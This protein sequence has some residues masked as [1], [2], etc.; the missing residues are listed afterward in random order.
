MEMADNNWEQ[1]HSQAFEQSQ[2]FDTFSKRTEDIRDKAVRR[3][4]ATED[5]ILEAKKL[6][7]SMSLE[8]VR[9]LMEKMQAVHNDDPNF[10]CVT[11]QSIKKF[12]A[13]DDVMEN[14]ERHKQ[15]IQE[16]K[17]EA[18]LI[19]NNSPYAEVRAV[20]D[21]HDDAG[22]PVSTTRA[23]TIGIVFSCLAAFANQSLRSKRLSRFDTD[24]I[25]LLAY[26]VGKA[27]ERW[28][29]RVNMRI[30]FTKHAISSN[31]GRFNKK[32][33]MLIVL[34]ANAS[35]GLPFAQYTIWTQVLPPYLNWEYTKSFPY[36][37]LNSF[38]SNLLGYGVAGLS[39]RFLVYPSRCV[40]PKSL[41]TIALNNALHNDKN[42][43]VKGPFG[44]M[45][46]MSRRAFFLVSF[47]AMF[48]YF[49]FPKFIFQKLKYFSWM[50]WIAPDNVMLNAVAG[51]K[52]GLG[53]LN[54]LPTFDWSVITTGNSDPLTIPAFSTFSFAGGMFIT[55]LMILGIWCTNTWNTAYLPVNSS[56]IFNHFGEV[57]DM[58]FVL[59]DNGKLD[60]EK[61]SSY[62]A[63]YLSA[64]NLVFYG[65]YFAL[66]SAVV[67]HVLLYYRHELMTGLGI[68]AQR[69]RWRRSGAEAQG[70]RE[71]GTARVINAEDLDV[72]RRLMAAYPQ[73]SEWFYFALVVISI[74]CGVL[75]KVLWPSPASPAVVLY[76][77][78]LC[79]LF[80]IPI[81][82]FAATTGLE[83]T[84]HVLSALIGSA[85]VDGSAFG[86]NFFATYSSATCTQALSI[87]KDFKIAHYVKIPPRVTFFGHLL[88]TFISTVICAAVVRS[89][90]LCRET[91][92]IRTNSQVFLT[93]SAFW[94]SI[95]PGKVFGFHGQY[96]WLLLGFPV[97]IVL[98]LGFFG[99]GKLMPK[100]RLLHRVH[101]VAALAGGVRWAPFSFSFSLP[102]VPVAWL[103]WIYMR[104]R[105]LAWWS[106]YNFVL[107]AALSTGIAM[108][109]I[110][111]A[112]TVELAGINLIWWGNT[113]QEVGCEGIPC[114][115]MVLDRGERFYPWWDHD[116]VPA[117]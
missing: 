68:A 112:S 98:V 115:L 61:Y 26:P 21:N 62:S 4:N 49:W 60:S 25:Q 85:F 65:T 95:G 13:L 23:W 9:A 43:P 97:G 46:T 109:A 84:L 79:I 55:G 47:L 56:K 27:W 40:W 73:V 33:H 14:P 28:V 51:M 37:L 52:N 103:S 88:A 15:L 77:T 19:T 106:K 20:A 31:P 58:V 5:D 108:S 34:M 86:M 35:R 54:P 8:H 11:M 104:S 99:L 67:T 87:A 107:S 82:I 48:V 42:Q 116:K 66:Y 6:A 110:M 117:P 57:Y 75:A 76:G 113:Q 59:D 83:V 30:P 45:W 69:L 7:A 36:I 100:N 70:D 96:K 22:M 81:G 10:P 114:P 92:A 80:M 32:E 53:L 71:K 72:H 64:A 2:F 24:T 93:A 1:S 91:N 44:W 94:G 18:A 29:P 105:H 111:I 78:W 3:F 12:L 50:T 89:Q 101:V 90:D 102:A 41:V 16:I 39:R 63:P 74:S 38:A 17:L